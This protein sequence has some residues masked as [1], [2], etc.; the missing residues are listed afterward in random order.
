M[1][2]LRKNRP[3]NIALKLKGESFKTE[4]AQLA[5]WDRILCSFNIWNLLSQRG[6]SGK[7]TTIFKRLKATKWTR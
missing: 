2:E 1:D 7:T 4:M 5:S 3:G 6:R